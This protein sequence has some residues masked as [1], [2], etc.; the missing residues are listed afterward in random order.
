[1]TQTIT[2]QYLTSEEFARCTPAT[3]HALVTAEVHAAHTAAA[4]R[5]CAVVL[6]EELDSASAMEADEARTAYVAAFDDLLVKLTA[7]RAEVARAR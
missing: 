5:R 3:A 1:M 2:S 6:P 4:V 7:A